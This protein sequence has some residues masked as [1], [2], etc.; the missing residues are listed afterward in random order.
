MAVFLKF[1]RCSSSCIPWH[2][3]MNKEELHG[4]YQHHWAPQELHCMEEC[5]RTFQW[6]NP[7]WIV[8]NLNDMVL[9]KCLPDRHYFPGINRI[10]KSGSSSGSSLDPCHMFCCHRIQT[11]P[12]SHAASEIWQVD[13]WKIKTIPE[14]EINYKWTLPSTVTDTLGVKLNHKR[15]SVTRL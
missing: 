15:P 6:H 12:P 4:S 11:H 13:L 9:S 14:I 5:W 1:Y 7:L 10:Y 8:M 2:W 3:C